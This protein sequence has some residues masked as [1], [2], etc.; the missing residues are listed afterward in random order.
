[1]K[2]IDQIIILYFLFGTVSCFASGELKV[3]EQLVKDKKYEEAVHIYQD[4]VKDHPTNSTVFFNLGSCYFYQ[5]KFGYAVWAYEKA[6]KYDPQDHEATANLEIC[7]KRLKK[8]EMWRS[9]IS[10]VE[11]TLYGFGANFWAY[12]SIVLSILVSIFVYYFFITKNGGGKKMALLS[13]TFFVLVCVGTVYLA[14]STNRYYTTS[15]F[16]I[17][18]SKAV[19]TYSDDL[20]SQKTDFS[21][22]EGDR[23]KI[24]H[25]NPHRYMIELNNREICSVD[26]VGIEKI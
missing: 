5:N 18:V 10:W 4:Y 21:L 14:F 8:A 11:R 26:K 16:A 1:M 2:L 25:E 13:I 24:V 7:Y 9:S 22:L 23:V 3:A 19:P 12:V 15:E 17:V 20:S 6:A